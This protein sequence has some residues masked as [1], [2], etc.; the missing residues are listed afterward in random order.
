MSNNQIANF[1]T[2]KLK[3]TTDSILSSTTPNIDGFT[4][5]YSANTMLNNGENRFQ[6]TNNFVWDSISNIIVEFSITNS[7]PTSGPTLIQ[8]M[9]TSNNLG[10]FSNDANHITVNSA[11][12]INLPTNS[13]NN[14]T[15]EITV[16]FWVNGNKNVRLS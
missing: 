13:L 6:F 7:T 15:D 8:G 5:V 9:Q 14:I 3:N 4:Q 11:E 16:S 10:I 12:S 1:L 2:I